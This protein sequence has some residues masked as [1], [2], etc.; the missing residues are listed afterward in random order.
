MHQI[1][2]Q[3][4]HFFGIEVDKKAVDLKIPA[5]DRRKM[6]VLD[7][8]FQIEKMDIFDMYGGLKFKIN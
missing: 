5:K 4:L 7:L 3:I 8:N 6:K 1:A 2:I